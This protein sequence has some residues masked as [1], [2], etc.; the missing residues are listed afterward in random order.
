MYIISVGEVFW[1][2]ETSKAA[3]ESH[4]TGGAGKRAAR[5]FEVSSDFCRTSVLK[6]V[7]DPDKS[8]QHR[9]TTVEAFAFSI[10]L[11]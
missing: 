10:P 4:T 9:T 3:F 5:D 6:V 11:L 2:L 7:D 8:V 1:G